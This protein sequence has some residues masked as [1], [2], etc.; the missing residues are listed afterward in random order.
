M[1]NHY[2]VITNEQVIRYIANYK[3]IAILIMHE[4]NLIQYSQASVNNCFKYY[5]HKGQYCDIEG[6]LNLFF[7]QIWASVIQLL[8]RL[9][10]Y[11]S[12]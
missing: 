8:S 3:P 6:G 1:K 12:C 7:N 11:R 10:G 9:V 5:L 4:E 2:I